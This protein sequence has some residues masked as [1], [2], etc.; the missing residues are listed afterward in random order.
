M[1]NDTDDEQR[2][3]DLQRMYWLEG[4][5]ASTRR[6]ASAARTAAA[7]LRHTGSRL[8]DASVGL[9]SVLQPIHDLHTPATWTG[10]AATQ[11]RRRLTAH[12]DR[13]TAAQRAIDDLIAD[14]EAEAAVQESFAST[15]DYYRSIYTPEYRRLQAELGYANGIFR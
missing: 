12:Q 15:Y 2:A 1:S 13:C 6:K 9:S 5:I 14:L 10:Q 3:A 4:E 7:D 11:S 8:D